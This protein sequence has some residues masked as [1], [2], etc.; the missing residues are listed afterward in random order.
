MGDIFQTDCKCTGQMC[1]CDAAKPCPGCSFPHFKGGEG[2]N[3]FSCVKGLGGCGADFCWTCGGPCVRYEK[4]YTGRYVDYKASGCNSGA[5]NYVGPARPGYCVERTGKQQAQKKSKRAA[6][7]E[8]L[9]FAGG[10]PFSKRKLRK[11]R[12]DHGRRL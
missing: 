11:P 4:K 12:K 6:L 8:R 1:K 2:C 7:L 9:L 3:H 10:G 5:C